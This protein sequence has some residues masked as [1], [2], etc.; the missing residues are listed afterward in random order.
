MQVLVVDWAK[1]APPDRLE[2]EQ[3]VVGERAVDPQERVVDAAKLGDQPAQRR[4]QR[5]LEAA[6]LL[7]EIARGWCDLEHD[8]A[9]PRRYQARL[10]EIGQQWPQQCEQT[11]AARVEGAQAKFPLTADHLERRPGEAELPPAVTPGIVDARGEQAAALAIEALGEIGER[12]VVGE[13]TPAP[14]D[15]EAGGSREAVIHG[16]FIPDQ[17]GRGVEPPGRGTQRHPAERPLSQS[18]TKNR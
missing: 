8:L 3:E 12:V 14:V 6:L 9:R 16:G 15:H 1:V 11:L 4:E 17:E 10:R 7:G 18:E 13:G 2:L 5:G